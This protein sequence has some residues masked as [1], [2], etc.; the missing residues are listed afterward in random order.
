[1]PA[2]GH[3]IPV[4]CTLIGLPSNVPVKPEHAPL[5]VHP[6]R[7]GIEERRRD[8]LGAQRVAGAQDVGG[9]VA[10]LGTQMDRHAAERI[11]PCA[12]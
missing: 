5:G 1:M 7:A 8:V 12:T 10:G 2:L 3:P 6:T 9:V 4:D 11:R